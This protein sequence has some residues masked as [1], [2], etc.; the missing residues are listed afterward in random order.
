MWTEHSSATALCAVGIAKK[1]HACFL[2]ANIDFRIGR[3]WLRLE[4]SGRHSALHKVLKPAW[5]RQIRQRYHPKLALRFW[6]L[7]DS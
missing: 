7:I 5:Q 4:Q 2:R 3:C 6:S 1:I